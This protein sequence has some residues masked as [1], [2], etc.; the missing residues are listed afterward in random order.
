MQHLQ[1]ILTERQLAA[2]IVALPFVSFALLALAVETLN[3]REQAS[4][5][6]AVV[7]VAERGER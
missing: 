3:I 1:S 4:A 7:R 2:A 6:R 5:A